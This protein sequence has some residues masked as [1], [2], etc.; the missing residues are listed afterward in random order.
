[1]AYD[2]GPRV[3]IQGEAE[4][5]K[6]IDSINNALRE[7]GSEMKAL[8]SEFESNA[9]S[10]DALIAKNKNL[11]RE[12]DL[13][14][15]KMSVL[16]GQYDKQV[17]KLKQLAE[18]YQ[19]AA[20]ENGENS[21][22]AA[23]A[24][25]AYNSQATT[26]SKLN[27]AMNET[28]NYI[29]KVNNEMDK[30]DALLD[31]IAAG[32]RDAAT[33]MSDLA[34]SADDASKSLESIDRNTKAEAMMSVA[35]GISGIGEAMMDV[36]SDSKDYLSIMGQLEASSE[37]LGY[38]T[39]ETSDIYNQL[40]G[41]LGDQQTAATTT[42]NL[43][44]LGLSQQDLASMTEL[45][46]GAW[47]QYGDSIPIDSLAEAI[48]ETAKVGTLTGGA[49]A[50]ALIWAGINEDEFNEKLAS[51]SSESERAQMIM[52]ALKSQGLDQVAQGYRDNNAAII[53]NNE[54][55]A[56]FDAAMASLAEQIMPA[57]TQ[58]INL[59]ASAL[60][61]I[62]NWFTSL[63]EPV[64]Q[65]ILIIAAL[66]A[67]F[68]VLA[69]VIT[70]VT[71]AT[72]ALN[73]SLLPIIGVIAA[74]AAAIVGIIA[75]IQNWGAIT[76]WLGGVVDT[77]TQAIGAAWDW[78][79]QAVGDFVQ[80]IVDFV[81]SGFDTVRKNVS[82]ALENVK[83]VASNI[84]NSVTQVIGDKVKNI[85]NSVKT[86]FDNVKNNV[87]SALDNVKSTASNIWNNITTTISGKVKNII[88]DVKTG[89]NTVK[90]NVQN[91]L[92]NMKNTVSNI[93]NNVKNTISN[94]VNGIKNNAVNGFR[95]LVSGIRNALSGV[96]N[97]VRNGFNGAINFIRGLPGQAWSWGSDFMNGLKNGIL[98][99][100]YAIRDAV[101]NIANSIRSFLHF[102]R[103]DE[104]PL[105]D[106]ETWMPDMLAGMADSI[107]SHLGIIQRAADAVSGTINSTI[108]GRVSDIA[109]GANYYS[110]GTMVIDGDTIVLD[111]KAIGKSATKY[112]TGNQVSNA[113]AKGRRV[114]YV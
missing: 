19:K 67:G 77:V 68:T 9:N 29:N 51:T 16:Q 102:S 69:P 46:I 62:L 99:K 1:M 58:A 79:C 108:T 53:A 37:R 59:A 45:A 101:A 89:F 73:V 107:Y 92:N 76:E 60:S 91:A 54:A 18:A 2:I 6:Q 75:V 105:R 114:R 33:G 93:W 43:Q 25:K 87:K 24:E 81:K 82:D 49:L 80:G 48:N 47:A 42:A 113:A 35:D 104:G 50:D 96:T 106:Y 112:I 52:E 44:A 88:N 12:L 40:Y 39:E 66:T 94:T 103:P 5:K 95:N 97:A 90:S 17:Q 11:Q 7:C 8:T 31:E 32:T 86:G 83:E 111:G 65:V 55:Q 74:V 22:E 34:D 63:P 41:V 64:Q 57:V 72:G 21:D 13:Q 78:V 28:R 27:V 15:Q 98:D 4:F 10:Q 20:Q 23:K 70:A 30:N 84:W 71:V 100:A 110:G 36:V 61:A 109:A 14:E 26:V 38:T 85:I 3:G 56:N